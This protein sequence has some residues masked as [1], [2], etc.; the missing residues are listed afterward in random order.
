MNRIDKY[1]FQQILTPLLFGITVITAVVW[2]TQSLQ[3]LE[4]VVEHGEGW[5]T[6]FWLTLLLIPSLLTIV[7]PFAIFG[8]TLFVLQRLHA[9]SEIAVLFSAGYSKLR[10]ATPLLFI[11][12]V[13]ALA[14]LW[15]NLDLM[16][17]TY[18]VLKE[19][20]ANIRADVAALLLRGGE[21][22]TLG[23]GYTIYIEESLSEGQFRGLVVND[24]RNPDKHETYMAQ[25]GQLKETSAGPMLFLSNGN[26]QTIDEETGAIDIIVF[27]QTAVNV[28]ALGPQNSVRGYRETTERYLDELLR[29]DRS[30][31]WDEK[32]FGQLIAEGH[33]RLAAP[34]YTF[35]FVLLAIFGLLGGQYSRRGYTLRITAVCAAASGLKVSSF[36]AQSVAASAGA[37]WL[38]YALPIIP[39]L[40]L[41]YLLSDVRSGGLKT[42]R[43]RHRQGAYLRKVARA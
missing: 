43:K 9:D 28:R 1:I 8:A 4:L 22:T 42:H 2:L 11:A 39:T 36:V 24:Y 41:M 6:F 14:V 13:G 10:L 26:I 40:A 35:A 29:P 27:E 31:P 18:R 16:P 3:R 5:A 21:F 32:N 12:F 34:F 37:Y 7:I 15:I 20:V 17:R 30:N 38:Q 33:A 19:E 25:F 23:D